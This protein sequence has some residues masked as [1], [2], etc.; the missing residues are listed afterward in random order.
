MW[1][2]TSQQRKLFTPIQG[3]V[4]FGFSCEI[5]DA[6]W[7]LI[8]L[9]AWESSSNFDRCLTRTKNARRFLEKIF[10]GARWSW[11][12]TERVKEATRCEPSSWKNRKT[13][14]RWMITNNTLRKDLNIHSFQPYYIMLRK[15]LFSLPSFISTAY[16]RQNFNSASQKLK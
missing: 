7:Y 11:I 5:F 13:T 16:R 9:K 1:N 6:C 2:I 8:A 15:S 10:I 12:I 4:S 14:K 3:I